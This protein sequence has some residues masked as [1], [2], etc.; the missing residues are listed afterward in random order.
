MK[1]KKR[2][3][4]AVKAKTHIGYFDG[5]CR[6]NPGVMGIGAVLKSG[7]DEIGR[8]SRCEGQGTCNRAEWLALI[9][10]L[11]LAIEKGVQVLEVRGDSRLVIQQ[12]KGKWRVKAR[13]LEPFRDRALILAKRFQSVR[14]I[15]VRRADNVEADKLSKKGRRDRNRDGSPVTWRDVV[16]WSV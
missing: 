10:L 1:L 12:V 3:S 15:H 5:A 6:P 13:E 14:F 11:E 2:D 8:V 16:R 9:A 4:G 7:D